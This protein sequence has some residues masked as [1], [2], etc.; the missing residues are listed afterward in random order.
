MMSCPLCGKGFEKSGKSACS[1]CPMG[2]G[3]ANTACC[4]HC[5]YKFVTGSSTIDLLK[6]VFKRSAKNV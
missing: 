2:A 1:S 4:P 5:G 3:C 6:R